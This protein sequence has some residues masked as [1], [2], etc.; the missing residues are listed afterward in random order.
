MVPYYVLTGTADDAI[1]YWCERNPYARHT[2]PSRRQAEIM[3]LHARADVEEL[4]DHDRAE[5]R[6]ALNGRT[7]EFSLHDSGRRDP[8]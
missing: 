2:A 3:L 1:A 4:S 8:V 7:T 6:V 5:A